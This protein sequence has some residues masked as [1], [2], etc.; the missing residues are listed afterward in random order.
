MAK[1][2]KEEK[3]EV[4]ETQSV[5]D[6]LWALLMLN[7]LFGEPPKETKVINIYMGDE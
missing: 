3:K 7:L 2:K 4:E 5:F 1:T 6:G